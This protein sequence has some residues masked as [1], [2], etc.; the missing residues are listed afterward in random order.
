M[1]KFS[2]IIPVYNV[3]AYLRE[4]LD[5]VLAQTC[6]DWEAICVN[7]G[8]TDGSLDILQEY[9]AKDAR[10]RF[11]D[12]HN[13]G[14]SAARN[15]GIDA[16]EGEYIFLLDSDD[17]IVPDALERL[18]KRINGQDIICFA[19]QKYNEQDKTYRPAD[20]LT[21]AM[22]SNGMTYYYANALKSYTFPF[23]CAVLRLYRRAFL[24]EHNLLFKEGIYHEDNL[25]TPMA[26][27]YARRVYVILD[28]LY[29]YRIRAHRIMT[30]AQPKRFADMAYVA[31]QLA[32][33]F[34]PKEKLNKAILYRVITH[35]YQ[36]ALSAPYGIVRK[37]VLPELDWRLYYEG[38]RTKP[39]HR[40]NYLKYRIK[41]LCALRL[42]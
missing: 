42:L 34:I 6:S 36:V 15:A 38:S 40:L 23:V 8:S 1:I 9:A 16:A 35:H 24:L 5:S 32:E 22:Y 7:D 19:G 33:F 17:W 26:C 4:C 13:K 30:T 28:S 14:L 25:F 21:P 37:Y 11:I 39:R 3:E 2:I 41:Y 29:I 27:Y 20:V 10:F 18:S 12:Q 31:N